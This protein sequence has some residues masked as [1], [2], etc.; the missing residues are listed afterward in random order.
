MNFPSPEAKFAAM[1]DEQLFGLTMYWEGEGEALKAERA[2]RT[3]AKEQE[4]ARID[5]ERMERIR[6]S[7]EAVQYSD[8]I[9]Q[10]ICERIAIGEL[11]INICDDEHLPDMRKCNQ[12]LTAR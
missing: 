4:Q 8:A 5:Q 11:L 7:K 6:A 3:K 1:P 2:K 10:E 9:A 12:W